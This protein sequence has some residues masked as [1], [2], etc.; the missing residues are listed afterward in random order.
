[1]QDTP[2]P[3]QQEAAR[4]YEE[5]SRLARPAPTDNLDVRLREAGTILEVLSALRP[6]DARRDPRLATLRQIEELYASALALLDR[7]AAI[8]SQD[9]W[10]SL[11]YDGERVYLRD[12]SGYRR[13]ANLNALRIARLAFAGDGDA[14]AD[15]IVATLRLRRILAGWFPRSPFKTAHS[16]EI[17]LAFAP[18]SEKALTLL[19]REYDAIQPDE[20]LEQILVDSRYGLARAFAPEEFGIP[21]SPARSRVLDALLY[22]LVRPARY[23]QLRTELDLYEAAMPIAREPWPERLD[24]AKRIAE[25]YERNRLSGSRRSFL[26]RMTPFRGAA[27]IELSSVT[28]GVAEGA[29]RARTSMAALAIERYRRV[30]GGALPGSLSDLTPEFLTAPL[31]DPYTGRELHYRSATS[32]YRIY[33]VGANR[34]DDGGEW[35]LTSDLNPFR[36]GDLKDLGLAIPVT[37]RI[38][39]VSRSRN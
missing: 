1:V 38:Q 6:A 5:A 31:V 11:R 17:V 13:L 10:A 24:S 37:S 30:H 3:E 16:L 2:T 23:H 14:A 7:A 25:P 12:V 32:G 28:P 9:S 39:D 26:D 33:S 20:A 8:E 18:P 29:A 4:L 21:G 15:A 35:E 19:G 22:R 34:T 36:R 27:M